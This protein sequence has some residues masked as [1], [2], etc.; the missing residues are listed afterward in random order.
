MSSVPQLQR[1][2]PYTYM[3]RFT[4]CKSWRNAFQMSVRE[5]VKPVA[6]LHEY[7]CPCCPCCLCCRGPFILFCFGRRPS[8]CIFY[9]FTSR[10]SWLSP[11]VNFTSKVNQN[12]KY[13][14]GPRNDPVFVEFPS[15]NLIFFVLAH[16]TLETSIGLPKSALLLLVG[17]HLPHRNSDLEFASRGSSPMVADCRSY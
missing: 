4:I 14:S 13:V 9:A 15:R 6:I 3:R 2:N 16:I 8:G 5:S 1:T 10:P 7:G 12:Q 17:I 11:P